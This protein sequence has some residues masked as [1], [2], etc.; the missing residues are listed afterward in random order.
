MNL[1]ISTLC[2]NDDQ[3]SNLL[4]QHRSN[5]NKKKRRFEVKREKSNYIFIRDH[6][7]RSFIIFSP[8]FF[9]FLF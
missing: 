5:T 3:L 2:E 4:F 7:F 1:L 8:L 9:C 6:F